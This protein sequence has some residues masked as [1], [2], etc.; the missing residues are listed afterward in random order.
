M[1]TSSV[2]TRGCASWSSTFATKTC[3]AAARR[4]RLPQALRRLQGRDRAGGRADRHPG[5]DGEGL[6]AR[7]RGR[8]PQRHAPDQEDDQ[9]S[10]AGAARA[11]LPPGP[12]PRGV[13]RGQGTAVL[14]AAGGLRRVP[15]HDGSPHG[16]RRRRPRRVV[17]HQAS[18]RAAASR[19]CS[20]SSTPG[21]A[22]RRSRPRWP[23]PACSATSPATRS[24]APGSCRSSPTRPARS[25]WTRCSA[26]SRS[27]RR[28]GRSTTRSTRSCCCRT[29]VEG[30]ADPRGGHH[31]SRLDGQLHRGG[32]GLR[33]P[34]R[35][36]GAVLHLLFDVRFPAGRRPDLGRGRRRGSRLPARRHRGTHDAAR[37]RSAAP[38]RPQP[39]CSHRP[40]R[41]ARPTTRR[42]PTRWRRSSATASTA[43]TAPM[44]FAR[45]RRL[46]LPHSLQRELRP[47]G[48]AGRRRASTTRSSAACTSGPTRPK[49][50]KR[51]GDDP[52]LRLGAGR[53]APGAGR[54]RGALRCRRRALVGDLVQEAARG[55]VV[56]RAVEPP[57]PGREAAH[58]VPVTRSW[59]RARARSSPS[60]TT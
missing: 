8:G 30:R 26:S 23:S 3:A 28:K 16:A 43:C 49:G 13:A 35:A 19:T 39:S 36:D 5:Q 24:S 42:S 29:R 1:S 54:S 22:S 44:R 46:L 53:G 20:A 6:D 34:R 4:P 37:R 59:P 27:T 18:A 10:A 55:S 51:H 38:G 9:R 15:L 52:V 21:R 57:A 33:D 7:L 11:A 14:P 2:P 32:H 12:D 17:H 47:A 31:R 50:P 41:R 58:A 25:G 48:Q 56:D 45:Q 40:C 60:P